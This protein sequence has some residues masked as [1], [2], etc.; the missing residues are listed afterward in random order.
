VSRSVY[1][2]ALLIIGPPLL[3]DNYCDKAYWDVSLVTEEKKCSKNAELG[4]DDAQFGY[5]LILLSGQ[6][7]ASKPKEAVEWIKKSAKQGNH[8][9][10][11]LL[12]RMLSD[13]RFGIPLALPE[14]YAWWAV[15][16]NSKSAKELW[17]RLTLEQ[18]EKAIE[19]AKKYAS[20]N[21][22]KQR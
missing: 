9:A 2:V 8:L 15:S 20:I 11:T 7:R 13:S 18:Q 19:L 17:F 12:G 6:N 10:Q 4:N 16:N 21:S 1:F 5:G 22:G 3:A 14:A